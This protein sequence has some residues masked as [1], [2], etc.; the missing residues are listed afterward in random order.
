MDHDDLKAAWQGQGARARLAIDAE[1]LFDEMRREER[2]FASTIFWRDFREVGVSLVM[3]PLWVYLGIRNASPWT[4]YLA[5]PA[6]LW[7]VGFL[8]VDRMRHRRPPTGPRRP[9]TRART[10]ADPPG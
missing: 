6:M 2:C 7:V 3:V 1:R 10:R 8:L 9:A 5:I 4:W